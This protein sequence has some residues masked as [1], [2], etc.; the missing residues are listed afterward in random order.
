MRLSLWGLLR[1]LLDESRAAW[2]RA[3]LL[4]RLL[5]Q[6]EDSFTNRRACPGE[7]SMSV[8][9]FAVRSGLR[10]V[11]CDVPGMPCVGVG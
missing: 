10:G 4:T 7:V 11:T 1:L 5:P 3:G 6:E 8:V 9:G 2:G